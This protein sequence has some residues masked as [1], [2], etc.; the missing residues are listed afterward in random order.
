MEEEEEGESTLFNLP[1][2]DAILPDVLSVLVYL[3]KDDGGVQAL[4]CGGGGRLRL[5][6]RKV[7]RR[8]GRAGEV[9]CK[10]SVLYFVFH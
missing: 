6:R 5:P 8:E 4:V 1:S 10:V 3:Q 2:W 7:E 9:P